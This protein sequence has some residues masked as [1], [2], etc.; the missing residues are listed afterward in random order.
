M[1]DNSEKALSQIKDADCKELT[2]LVQA[3]LAR[4]DALFP[5]DE[6]FFLSLPKHDRHE[7]EAILTRFVEMVAKQH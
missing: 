7:R 4:Y 3:I 5:E 2:T 1:M 6:V